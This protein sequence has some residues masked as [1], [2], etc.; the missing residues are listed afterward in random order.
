MPRT[1]R[2]HPATQ[3][4]MALRLKV[5][6]ELEELEKMLRLVPERLRSGGQVR[7]F[8]I[9]VDGR[10]DSETGIS[11]ACARGAGDDSD[12]ACRQARGGRSIGESG[13]AQCKTAGA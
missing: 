11:G 2:I 4:F 9:H 1:G 6:G 12:E 8:D 13:V 7:G 5:N 3:T 10:P